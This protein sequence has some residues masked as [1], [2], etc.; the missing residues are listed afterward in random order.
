L[1]EWVR[2]SCLK[3]ACSKEIKSFSRTRTKIGVL[4]RERR[5]L[6]IWISRML[7]N[8]LSGQPPWGVG[9]GLF[10]VPT[11]K[12]AAGEFFTGQVR[13]TSLEADRNSLEAGLILDKSD[14]GL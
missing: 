5:E 9:R 12:R 10:I 14:E 6:R 1:R 7:F 4:E 2:F 13:W 8:F 11:S 3:V